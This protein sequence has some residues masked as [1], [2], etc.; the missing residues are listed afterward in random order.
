MHGKGTQDTAY[1]YVKRQHIKTC[2]LVFQAQKSEVS[3]S[4]QSERQ[5][6]SAGPASLQFDI[7]HHNNDFTKGDSDLQEEGWHPRSQ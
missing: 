2:A 7:H 4:A 3:P 6:Q 5:E 1:M